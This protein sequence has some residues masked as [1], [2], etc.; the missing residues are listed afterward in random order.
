[1]AKRPC[2]HHSSAFEAKVTL[3]A[4]KGDKTLVVNPPILVPT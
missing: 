2:R 3:T 4:F 1:M